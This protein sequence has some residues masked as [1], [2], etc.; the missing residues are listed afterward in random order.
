MSANSG[1]SLSRVESVNVE[2]K[3]IPVCGNAYRLMATD[4]QR[5]T[6]Y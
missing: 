3:M 5:I 4:D 1:P 2:M 6:V